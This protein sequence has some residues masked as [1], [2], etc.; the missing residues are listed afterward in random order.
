MKNIALIIA[1]IFGMNMKAQTGLK[2]YEVT[3]QVPEPTNMPCWVGNG[4][5]SGDCV[6]FVVRCIGMNW[7]ISVTNC[8]LGNVIGFEVDYRTPVDIS[9]PVNIGVID[10]G[11]GFDGM[12]VG[13]YQHFFAF[14][15]ADDITYNSSTSFVTIKAGYYE[16][17]DG[18]LKAK[19]VRTQ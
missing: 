17:I 9:E 2:K 10:D 16:V 6:T 7:G 12:A 11:N 14:Y 1:L 15:L 13:G 19:S 5:W 3:P 8:G 4:S 18:K